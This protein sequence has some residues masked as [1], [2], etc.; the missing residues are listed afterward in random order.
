MKEHGYLPEDAKVLSAAVTEKAGRWFVSLQVE[1]EIPDSAPRV[2]HAVGVDVG[3]R[4]LAV[5]SDEQVFDNPQA[6]KAAEVR[7]RRAQKAVSR[8]R[9]G[10]QNRRK[11]VA[12][13]ARLHYR[14]GNVRKDALH[15]AASAITKSASVVVLESLNVSG[16]LRNRHLSKALSDASVAELHRQ[17]EYKA[18]WQGAVVLK[19]PPFYPSSKMCSHC[20]NVKQDLALGDR[21]YTCG[22][23]GLVLDRDL[24]AAIN[25]RNLAA[26][27]AVTACGEVG[28]GPGRT[29][30]TKPASAKQEPNADRGLSL[31]GSV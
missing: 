24:N 9:K 23:C 22:V 3:I 26:S 29:T 5:T 27:S 17:I 20:G 19:A 25:L 31:I 12:R 6:L 1:Q 4:H 15:K 2:E 11:A 28:S 13:V 30:W 21:T 8:R 16:M 7:L 10:S 14:I 18:R